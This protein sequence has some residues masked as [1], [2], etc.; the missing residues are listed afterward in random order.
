MEPNT[1]T[2]VDEL[3]VSIK[4][5]GL[6]PEGL[7]HLSR[8]VNPSS[9]NLASRKTLD[10]TKFIRGS[11]WRSGSIPKKK[12]F[13]QMVS[14]EENCLLGDSDTV[15][16]LAATSGRMGTQ[17]PKTKAL[18]NV[19]LL[20]E[21][22]DSSLN[23]SGI[24]IHSQEEVSIHEDMSQSRIMTFIKKKNKR[25]AFKNSISGHLNDY[26]MIAMFL[27][28]THGMSALGQ[29][30]MST[31]RRLPYSPNELDLE[32]LASNQE[33]VTGMLR[34]LLKHQEKRIYMHFL[35]EMPSLDILFANTSLE[36]YLEFEAEDQ[37]CKLLSELYRR[38]DSNWIEEYTI[39]LLIV[40]LKKYPLTNIRELLKGFGIANSEILGYIVRT[41]KEESVLALIRQDPV[42]AKDLQSHHIADHKMYRIAMVLGRVELASMLQVSLKENYTLFDE[43]LLTLDRKSTR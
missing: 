35:L 16:I 10:A 12:N 33:F 21:A 1:T 3:L 37:M 30:L 40:Y 20:S 29:R 14:I 28:L 15:E 11:K 39:R 4:R 24:K 26:S 38:N 41:G 23:I 9:Q 31:Q 42:L 25:R 34:S 43:I 32:K 13:E 7:V 6:S 22:S 36:I 18:L 2:S 19:R 27:S 5:L 17:N 8:M